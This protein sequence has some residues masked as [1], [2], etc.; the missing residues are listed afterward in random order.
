MVTIRDDQGR[1]RASHKYG[2]GRLEHCILF[3]KGHLY[4]HLSILRA[5]LPKSQFISLTPS[6]AHKSFRLSEMQGTGA[7]LVKYVG[8]TTLAHLPSA[9]ATAVQEASS[10]IE[11][12]VSKLK[13]G[14]NLP[15]SN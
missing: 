6:S 1:K 5:F 11:A 14:I 15:T 8:S 10:A 2:T 12:K 7:R 13:T 3:I 4:Q 9:F